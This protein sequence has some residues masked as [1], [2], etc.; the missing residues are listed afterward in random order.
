MLF[1]DYLDERL[2]SNTGLDNLADALQSDPDLP[3]TNE[4]DDISQYMTDSP[5]Y[6]ADQVNALVPLWKTYLK[7]NRRTHNRFGVKQTSLNLPTPLND[8]IEK[9]RQRNNI[10]SY[11]QAAIFL[12]EKGLR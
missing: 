8:Q 10:Q 9:Y 1:Q 4:F 11:N 3:R 5:R 2:T 7:Q 12:I 6:T